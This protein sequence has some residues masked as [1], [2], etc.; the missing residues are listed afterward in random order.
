MPRPKSNKESDRLRRMVHR[1]LARRGSLAP[2]SAAAGAHLDEDALSVFVEGRLSER[3][4]APLIRH[5]VA[6]ASC[7]H[8]TTHLIRLDT[9]LSVNETPATPAPAEGP[10]RI[11]RLLADLASRV[12]PSS[13][14]DV[15]F[16]YHAPADDFEKKG[17]AKKEEG[18]ADEAGSEDGKG[19]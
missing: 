15:V 4:A 3:E 10:G 12:L 6:C 13:E 1:H 8:I 11:R 2:A 19:N 9:E 7:R 18:P 17:E 5:L 16:A 14:D